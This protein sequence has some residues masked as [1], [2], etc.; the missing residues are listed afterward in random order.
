MTFFK[1]LVT[2]DNFVELLNNN[3]IPY[4]FDFCNIDIDGNDIHLLDAL[5]KSYK[6]KLI[7]IEADSRYFKWRKNIHAEYNINYESKDHL[8]AQASIIA[9][10]N[11]AESYQ[12]KCVYNNTGNVFFVS[13]T[14]INNFSKLSQEEI[15]TFV[16]NSLNYYNNDLETMNKSDEYIPGA[17]Y[18]N[19]GMKD[20]PRQRLRGIIDFFRINL[21]E[22]DNI[23]YNYPFIPMYK[24]FD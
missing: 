18:K 6:P 21:S 2:P 22:I 8:K 1:E 23:N 15:K 16:V 13:D 17:P 7:C 19:R 5:L 24:I 4:D 3:N 11:I 10:N 9:L 20:H 12:Y 14:Y